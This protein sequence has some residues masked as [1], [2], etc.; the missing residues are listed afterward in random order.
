MKLIHADDD[1]KM[2]LPYE[3][4]IIFFSELATV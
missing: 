4:L 3:Y 1:D 2:K